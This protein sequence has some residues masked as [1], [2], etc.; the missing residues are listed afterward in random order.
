MDHCR[1]QIRDALA[2]GFASMSTI[3]SIHVARSTPIEPANLP[4]LVLFTN[5]ETIDSFSHN[6]NQLRILTITIEIQIQ[7]ATVVDILDEIAAE[8]EP[9][10]FSSAPAWVK[11][12]NLVSTDIELSGDAIQQTGDMQLVFTISYEVNRAAPDAPL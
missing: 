12:I 2:A 9:L 5:N 11:E 4:G 3:K 8:V 1:K 10:V 7:A 6:G